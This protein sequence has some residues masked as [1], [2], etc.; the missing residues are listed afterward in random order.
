[1][2]FF[3]AKDDVLPVGLT[4]AQVIAIAAVVIG[5]AILLVRRRPRPVVQSTVGA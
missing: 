5:L 2:E 1:M 4:I 3:R